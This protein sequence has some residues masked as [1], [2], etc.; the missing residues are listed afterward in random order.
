MLRD[1]K[2]FRN[3][4]IKNDFIIFKVEDA[5]FMKRKNHQNHYSKNATKK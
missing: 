3:I 5:K 4:F 1:C 2:T